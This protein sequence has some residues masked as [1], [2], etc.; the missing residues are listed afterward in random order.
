MTEVARHHTI[1]RLDANLP[2]TVI[3][4]ELVMLHLD[5][6]LY[7]GLNE[8]G[9]RVW[10]L[11]ETPRTVSDL[12]T[13]LTREFDIEADVCESEV[14]AFLQSLVEVDLIEVR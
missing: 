7:I 8:V 11:L 14:V 4:D 10:E 13:D 6:S 2:S 5:R 3:D 9:S 12:C 1:S